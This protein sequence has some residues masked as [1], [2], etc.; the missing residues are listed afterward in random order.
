MLGRKA[1]S[2][3][4]RFRTTRLRLGTAAGLLGGAALTG[5][6]CLAQWPLSSRASAEDEPGAQAEPGEASRLERLVEQLGHDRFEERERATSRLIDAGDAAVP[7]L[8]GGARSRDPEISWRSKDILDQLGHGKERNR[9]RDEARADDERPA[10]WPDDRWPAGR[11]HLTEE[12]ARRMEEG[13]RAMDESLARMHDGWFDRDVL[14]EIEQM[15]ERLHRRFDRG[16]GGFDDPRSRAGLEERVER[17]LEE[18]GGEDMPAHDR[19]W[20]WDAEIWE[21]GR[22]VFEEHRQSDAG[23]APRLGI[24]VESV[25]P[26]L[27]AQLSLEA[28]TGAVV[29]EVHPEGRA[30]RAGFER[31]DVLLSF[32]GT[33]VDGVDALRELVRA[34]E[35]RD[36]VRAEIVRRGERRTLAVNMTESDDEG[37][38]KK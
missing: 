7:F 9:A 10:P 5:V 36:G 30:A 8:E 35:A 23:D 25:H 22:K 19:R 15:T 31:Y 2:L 26:A 27:R 38:E 32:D 34:A 12:F 11:R 29:S 1:D 24:A 18:F 16:P 17:L 20:R 3:V 6:L 37:V 14:R 4:T 21:N 28:G 33:K 13:R